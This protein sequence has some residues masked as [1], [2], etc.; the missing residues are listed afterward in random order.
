MPPNQEFITSDTAQAAYL[1]SQGH[2]LAEIRY[3]EQNAS[4]IFDNEDPKLAEDIRNFQLVKAEGNIVVF[5]NIYRD[6]IK[7]I[8]NRLPV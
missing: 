1:I 2:I 5:N 6:L 7:R 8:K 3:G 4:F